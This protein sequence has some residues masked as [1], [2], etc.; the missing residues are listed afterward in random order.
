MRADCKSHL[1][2]MAAIMAGGLLIAAPAAAQDAAAAMDKLA[3]DLSDCP[4]VDVAQTNP[5]GSKPDVPCTRQ[6][7]KGK[8]V[9]QDIQMTFDLGSANLTASA[10]ATLDRFAAALV[11][12][13]SFRPFTVEGHTDSSGSR[14]LNATLSR[15]RAQSVTDYLA[16]KGVDR[17][18]MTARGYGFSRPLAGRSASD[19][20]NRRVEVVAR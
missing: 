5:D 14:A 11:K 13:G 3:E 1:K 4:A 2:L 15:A 12:V 7:V 19:P 17:S 6:W 18:R 10:R 20:A 8:V 16:S 9:R